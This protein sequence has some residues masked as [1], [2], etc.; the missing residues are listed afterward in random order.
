MSSAFFTGLSMDFLRGVFSRSL[1]PKMAGLVHCAVSRVRH[2]V[3]GLQDGAEGPLL[4][5]TNL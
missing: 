4:F 3:S 5:A 2:R 1:E